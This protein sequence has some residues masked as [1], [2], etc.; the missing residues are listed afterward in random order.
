M[1]CTFGD[2]T[3]IIW[4]RELNLPT[5]ALIGATA[6]SCRPTSATDGWPS[7]DAEAAQRL[8]RRARGQDRQPGARRRRRRLRESGALIGELREITHPSSSTRRASGPSRSSR[9]ASGS[10]DA[11][12]PRGAPGARRGSSGT[13]TTCATATAPG[14]KAST[15]TG[16]SRASGS[17][18]C[19]SRSGTRSTSTA[20]STSTRPSLAGHRR[21]ARRPLERR[22]P[23][24]AR[25]SATSPTASS[26]TPTSWTP[27]RPVRCPPRSPALGHRPLR[28]GLPDGPATPGPR[29]HPH[30]ALLDGRAQ[31]LRVQRVLPFR[32]R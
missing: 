11:R 12:A 23:G 19:P 10:C 25:T 6:G 9:R 8:R 1:I 16:T 26:A 32:T 17:S 22:P 27:G 28:T 31:S 3:D 14:S 30:L 18:A 15:S 20:R 7:R 2:V 21:T 5:R 4:W 29:D 24:Y 13:P